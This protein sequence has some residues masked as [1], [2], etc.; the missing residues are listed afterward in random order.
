MSVRRT[1][2]ILRKEFYH[3][4]RDIRLL[5]L[6]TV[7]PAFLLLTFSYVFAMDLGQVTMA[8]MDQD[9][10][11]L[12]RDYLAALTADG[13]VRLVMQATSYEE[14]NRIL[15]KGQADVVL[16]IPPGFE[17]EALSG[18]G[19]QIQLLVDGTDSNTARQTVSEFTAR[20]NAFATRLIGPGITL[21]ALVEPHSRVL[22]NPGLK[23]LVSMVPGLL[24]VVLVMPALA[25]ALALTREKEVG[26]FETLITTPVSG[27]EYLVG[28][29]TAYI[30]AGMVSLV[31]ALGVAVFWF[32]VPFRGRLGMFLLLTVIFYGANM[33]ISLIL[34]TFIKNQQ[35]A[36]FVMLLVS[37]V[38][39]FFISGLATPI[40]KTSL[41]SEL[42]SYSLPTTHFIAISR[43]VFLKGLGLSGLWWHTAVLMGMGTMALM[44]S[45]LLFKKRID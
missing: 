14:A 8:V 21:H 15:V 34:A 30:G 9:H 18:R 37:L 43:G 38:P 11:R 36:M 42:I 33:G 2:A 23:S 26:T 27:I 7:S 5:F 16:I 31:I 32:H 41:G 45:V 44:L 29:L 19:A 22:Y 28:K 1:I 40:N 12:S 35:T 4:A 39:S 24:A 17:D 20:T 13:D 6:V 10:S 3:I 25:L